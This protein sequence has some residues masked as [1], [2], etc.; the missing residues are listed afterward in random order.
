MAN[1]I[2]VGNHAELGQRYAQNN[3]RKKEYVNISTKKQVASKWQNR[4]ISKNKEVRVNTWT[5][6]KEALWRQKM[7]RKK[8]IRSKEESSN[9]RKQTVVVEKRRGS[10][11]GEENGEREVAVSKT[12]KMNPVI[13]E[14]DVMKGN[15]M[16]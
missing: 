10:N 2:I 3:L 1:A 16:D 11:G 14:G 15:M 12:L 8:E 7:E 6:C 4:D 5:P 13:S 9:N